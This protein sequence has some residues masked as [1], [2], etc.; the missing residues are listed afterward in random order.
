MCE[1]L[2]VSVKNALSKTGSDSP[3]HP[4]PTPHSRSLPFAR[5][6]APD[7]SALA[8]SRPDLDLLPM[9]TMVHTAIERAGADLRKV[10]LASVVLAGGNSCCRGFQ[11]R[12]QHEVAA[13]APVALKVKVVGPGVTERKVSSWI[14]G[15]ILGSM[16]SFHEMYMSKAEYA[17]HGAGLVERKCP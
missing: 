14:G 6:Q 2:M 1:P 4:T 11:E 8:A 9:Q 16:G 3:L 15:S 10:L 12:L 13:L 5:S 17:E 7:G